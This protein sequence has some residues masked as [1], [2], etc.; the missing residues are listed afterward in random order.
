MFSSSFQ[1][2]K[3][4]SYLKRFSENLIYVTQISLNRFKLVKIGLIKFK[5]DL[6]WSKF[7]KSNVSL[8]PQICLISFFHILNSYNLSK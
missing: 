7:I 3:N 5:I 6:N 1:C 2:S 8:N 4:R